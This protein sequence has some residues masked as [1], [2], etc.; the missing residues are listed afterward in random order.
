[1]IL[2]VFLSILLSFLMTFLGFLHGYLWGWPKT[3]RKLVDNDGHANCKQLDNSKKRLKSSYMD[4]VLG[5]KLPDVI[6]K[7]AM[8]VCLGD[9]WDNDIYE[10]EGPNQL[11]KGLMM[12]REKELC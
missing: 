8:K 3:L 6:Q 12:K 5:E 9:Y 1:M 2:I 10:N 4:S 7:Y 11:L